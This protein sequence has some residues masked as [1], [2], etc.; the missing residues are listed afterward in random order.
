MPKQI[1]PKFDAKA[2]VVIDELDIKYFLLAI[3]EAKPKDKP[4]HSEHCAALS[5]QTLRSGFLASRLLRPVDMLVA[6]PIRLPVRVIIVVLSQLLPEQPT[7]S[8]VEPS[9]RVNQISLILLPYGQYG[10]VC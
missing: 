1:I 3:V 6:K 2:S 8:T 4:V 9:A 7:V 5:T 10:P